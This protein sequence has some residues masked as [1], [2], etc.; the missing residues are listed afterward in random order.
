[1]EPPTYTQKFFAKVTF[2]KTGCWQWHGAAN[3]RGYGRFSV[4]GRGMPAHRYSYE[5]VNGPVPPGKQL[6][7]LCRNHSCVNPRHLEA[8]T[9]RENL[10]RGNTKAAENIRKTHCK[11]GHP[12]TEENTHL[13]T[14]AAGYTRRHCRACWPAR[15]L[16]SAEY[17]RQYYKQRNAHQ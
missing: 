7:H 9:P 2:E 3:S 4:A 13:H 17:R 12:Y 16:R 5:L 10:M 8:V 1:M 11:Y 15:N 14:D 6:D